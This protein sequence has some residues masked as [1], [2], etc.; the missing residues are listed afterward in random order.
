MK[1]DVSRIARIIEENK[2]TIYGDLFSSELDYNRFVGLDCSEPNLFIAMLKQ[3]F[4]I[5]DSEIEEWR[6]LKRLEHANKS[7]KAAGFI[8]TGERLGEGAW[9]VV[10]E[11]TDSNKHRWAIKKLRFTDV[12]KMQAEHRNLS[13]EQ[14]IQKESIPLSAA[15]HNIVPRIVGN[16]FIAMPVYECL[17][18]R[19]EE[20]KPLD[21]IK[22]INISRQICH[23]LSYMHRNLKRCYSDIKPSNVL[24]DDEGNALLTDLGTSTFISHSQKSTD[25]RDN[26]GEICTR[27]PECFI[28]G[29]HPDERSDVYSLGAFIGRLLMGYFPHETRL[30]NAKDPIKEIQSMIPLEANARTA[31]YSSEVPSAFYG[32]IRKC[33]FHDPN[34]RYKTAKEAEAA[35][36]KSIIK[37]ERTKPKARAVRWSL[38]GLSLL[39]LGFA[40]NNYFESSRDRWNLEQKIEQKSQEIDREGKLRIVNLY[41]QK[42]SLGK[43]PEE[44]RSSREDY[45][46]EGRLIGWINKF[47][48]ERTGISAYLDP[49]FTFLAIQEAGG[50]TSYN[51]IKEILVQKNWDL[52]WAVEKA[53]N[54]SFAYAQNPNSD[55]FIESSRVQNIEEANLS[56]KIMNEDY[57]RLS[58]LEKWEEEAY[59]KCNKDISDKHPGLYG[60]TA[61]RGSWYFRNQLSKEE[62]GKYDELLKLREKFKGKT[63][64]ADRSQR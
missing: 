33:L 36:E 16:D 31:E 49:V 17:E 25:P 7:V 30:L 63:N 6:E 29:S 62:T 19:L 11:Y 21:T 40:T 20:G 39:G 51:N 42:K 48:D 35:L 34:M 24:I 12:S 28:E 46:E 8:P 41:L 64:E 61:E 50:K 23:A 37:Y 32:F 44:Y 1:T 15:S 52:E 14:A 55:M 47:A 10:D 3:N 57:A 43:R 58:E 54:R 56:W 13:L 4:G 45:C 2:N 18:N 27:A 22:A 5:S 9:G 26:I 59:K 60:H 53:T 38:I